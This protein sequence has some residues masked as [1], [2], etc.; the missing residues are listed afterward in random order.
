MN[1]NLPIGY[2][3]KK[4]SLE[5]RSLLHKLMYLTYQELF[6][7]QE[8]FSHL[9]ETINQYFSANTP[10]WLVQ[11][12]EKAVGKDSTVACLWMG[13][14]IDQ[15]NGERYAHIFLLFVLPEYR[16]QGIGTTLVRV[17]EIWAKARGDRQIGLQVFTNNQ[18]ALNLYHHL[19]F[20]TQSI[21]MTKPLWKRS[22]TSAQTFEKFREIR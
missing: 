2:Q 1:D 5:D 14:A 10:L 6:S 21:F 12:E 17:A 19:G 18:P 9:I 11:R 3:L 4:G 7:H 22:H 13:N 20:Q 8:N 15:V 16:R